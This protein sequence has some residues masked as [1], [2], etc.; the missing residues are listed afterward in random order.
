MRALVQ[1]VPAV[2]DRLPALDVVEQ[3]RHSP[4]NLVLVV[5]EH[6]SLEGI[7]TEGD[8]LKTIVA[9]IQEDEGPD[10][11]ARRRFAADRR[12]LSN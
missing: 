8:I 3:L 9:D 7:V 11:A 6:G 1:K 12:R 10:R 2:S 5:D 4:L